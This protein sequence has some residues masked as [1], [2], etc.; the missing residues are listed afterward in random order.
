[1][2]IM[3]VSDKSLS[4]CNPK[5]VDKLLN[6]NSFYDVCDVENEFDCGY[7][8]I[9]D[10]MFAI[11]REKR[12]KNCYLNDKAMTEWL[13]EYFLDKIYED[14]LKEFGE[15]INKKR[16]QSKKKQVKETLQSGKATEKENSMI[17]KDITKEDLAIAMI[18]KTCMDTPE[19]VKKVFRFE[20]AVDCKVIDPNMSFVD[21]LAAMIVAHF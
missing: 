14:L 17:S 2:K 6:T 15:G 5:L 13:D 21:A 7:E 4:E 8:E 20:D 10:T 3:F 9:V 16:F 11:V 18:A 1:M 19:N 12:I